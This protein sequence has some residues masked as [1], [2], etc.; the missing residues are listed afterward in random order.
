MLVY[1]SVYAKTYA[2]VPARSGKVGHRGSVALPGG[3]PLPAAGICE[4]LSNSRQDAGATG[5]ANCQHKVVHAKR[6]QHWQLSTTPGSPS[7]EE[8]Q[9]WNQWH[10]IRASPPACQPVPTGKPP[11]STLAHCPAVIHPGIG[12]RWPKGFNVA[13][14]LGI[15]FEIT[16]LWRPSMRPTPGQWCAEGPAIC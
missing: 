15:Y 4:R 16:H 8:F 11:A 3:K 5:C 7:N 6:I 1:R 13:A 10:D 12:M 9:I 2:K 14:C